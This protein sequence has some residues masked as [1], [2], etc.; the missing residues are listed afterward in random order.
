MRESVMIV[1]MCLG[2]LLGRALAFGPL[3]EG[4][5]ASAAIAVAMTTWL[6]ARRWF[7]GSQG[8]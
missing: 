6:V 1:S 2:L 7:D 4:L 3:G 8:R 5:T